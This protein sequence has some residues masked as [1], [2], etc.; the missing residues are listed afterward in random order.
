V[1]LDQVIT[2]WRERATDARRLGRD[3]Q[4]LAIDAVLDDLSRAAEP[5]TR[6]LAEDRAILYSRKS[7]RWLRAR[8]PEW[9]RQG[10]AKLTGNRRFYLPAALPVPYDVCTTV[11]DAER[12]AREDERTREETHE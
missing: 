7:V 1:T 11:A 6:W 10:L 9:E 2:D 5:F 8:F 4:A 12:T 3:D